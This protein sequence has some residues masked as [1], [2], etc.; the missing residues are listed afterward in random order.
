[1]CLHSEKTC[2]KVHLFIMDF[3]SFMVCI[4]LLLCFS[5]SLEITVKSIK[6]SD[7]QGFLLI[8]CLWLVHAVYPIDFVGKSYY[9]KE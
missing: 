9:G 4:T 6:R 7:L 5:R 3:Q 8:R 2:N 1:M